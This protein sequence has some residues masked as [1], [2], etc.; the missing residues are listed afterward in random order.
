MSDAN[1]GLMT[2]FT[3]ALE[4]SE[5]AARAAYLDSVCGADAAVRQR[6]KALQAAHAGAGRFLEPDAAG[7][8][9]DPT[10]LPTDATAAF[11]P[12]PQPP[13]EHLTR[14]DQSDAGAA[15]PLVEPFVSTVI[16][17]R[18]TLVEIIGEGGMG[19]VYLAEQ[20]EPVKRHVALKL[21]KGGTDSR[22]VLARFE[23]ER[24]AL[25]LMDHPNIARVYDG[26]TTEQGQPFFVMELVRGVPLTDYCDQHRL[27]VK[28]RLELFVQVC[29]AVQH[30]HQ[31]GIIH[32]DLK[33]SNVLVT[34][35]DGR[36]TPKV[37][38]FGVAKATEVR[39]TDM[40]YADTGAIVGT[41]AYMSPEQADPSS[42][43]IDTRSD[44]Y[45][46]G[47]MLYELLVGSPPIDAKQ[48][49]RG[50]ILEMLRMV[51][52]VDPP[53]PSTK[54]SAADDLPNIAANRDIEPARLA[55]SLRGELDWV[56]MKALE[57]DRGRRYDSANGLA[58]DLQRY[59]ADEVLEARPPSRGYRL[60]KF[61][62][63]HK[64]QVTTAS[65]VFFAL[66]AGVVG[67]AWQAVQANRARE[68]E[69]ARA[70]S[71]GQ[72]KGAA[73]QAGNQLRDARDE[74]WANLYVS[75]TALIQ[76][77]WDAS[78]YGRVRKLLAAQVPASGQRDL[79]GF[80]W[81]YLD[82]QLNA[83]LKTVWLPRAVSRA[84][85]ISPDGTRLLR[86]VED[87]DG[88]WLKSFDTSTGQ[89]VFSLKMPTDFMSDP[90]FST[91][92][93]WIVGPVQDHHV[94]GLANL[95][96]RELR[97]WDAAT[98]AEDVGFR[99]A[100][101]DGLPL[102]G[103]NGLPVL[104]KAPNASPLRAF[105]GPPKAQELGLWD[106]KTI[107]T[108]KTAPLDGFPQSWA[109]SPDGNVLAI[110]DGEVKLLD[111][112]TGK[113]LLDLTATAS[114]PGKP[115]AFSADGKQLAV[116]G[117]TL[118]VWEVAYGRKM[119]EVNERVGSPVFSPDGSRLAFIPG[120]AFAGVDARIVDV[121]S[122]QVRRVLRGHDGGITNP[123]FTYDGTV[124]VSAGGD[125][126]KY[127]DATIDDRVPALKDHTDDPSLTMVTT[128]RDASR[129]ARG[130]NEGFQ[131]WGRE[132]KPIYI[133]PPAQLTKRIRPIVIPFPTKPGSAGS[134]PGPVPLKPGQQPIQPMPQAPV[135]S[136][137]KL[138]ER[139]ACQ[140]SPDGR[141]VGWWNSF[142]NADKD[143][144]KW[145]CEVM[146][147]DPDAG[148]QLV[149]GVRA[150][151]ISSAAFSPD[152]RRMAA[153]FEPPGEV[154]VW[155]A[156]TGR[157]LFTLPTPAGRDFRFAFSPDGDRLGVIGQ[158]EGTLVVG[159]WDVQTGQS[160]PSAGCAL[161]GW[162]PHKLLYPPAFDFG[163]RRVALALETDVGPGLTTTVVRVWDAAT[164]SHPVDLNGFHGTAAIGP[165]AFSPD[166]HRL[167]IVSAGKVNL[168]DPDTGAELLSVAVDANSIEQ[169]AFASD[170]QAIDLVVKTSAG[171]ERRRLDGRPREGGNPSSPR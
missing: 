162:K 164:G 169:F 73:V 116:A 132:D 83:D 16:A 148:R 154:K 19:S 50:A 54:L 143:R 47:V 87:A 29:Q 107:Q 105:G 136:G 152:G 155:D 62:R 170:G 9:D 17:G 45:A 78:Q 49:K 98:G 94:G 161:D 25:A 166:G 68:A 159:L 151:R 149:G 23:A 146:L 118:T 89:P 5:P 36:P 82:R 70:E 96:Q 3:E 88:L 31:K 110:S 51:R 4:L 102:S 72:A 157:E 64:G 133:S 48:F 144:D 111:L 75:Q 115:V 74:L 42:M 22:A 77:A 35:V 90:S 93:K 59:L 109:L 108:I 80:E 106:G 33:P 11:D 119:L 30:A 2:I 104:C 120:P 26:G 58:R 135:A 67:T 37:I 20:T 34:E 137:P 125:R 171:F 57:K 128:S 97:R 124:L 55:K 46:L 147:C 69:A 153:L 165:M 150:G 129:L 112:R 117:E 142:L 160:L 167:A 8:P 63:R 92:G 41:P 126:I 85:P 40:S 138:A 13:T 52:E 56:V 38:D 24:Q 139:R 127:W 53:R 21:I 43:D 158:G 32:R 12:Q 81:Y 15:T 141:R 156:E 61:V 27:P 39:L 100:K 122:G 99:G 134:K 145:E 44:V 14:A 86:Y 113:L 10:H 130:N 95:T 168:W 18:Y 163:A 114:G 6:V 101:C 79:R 65:L 140:L 121:A 28:A 7:A 1:P 103:P 131:V 66:L 84:A 60:K 71:E 76:A 91:D 123:A